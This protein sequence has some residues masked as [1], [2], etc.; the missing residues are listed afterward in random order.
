MIVLRSFNY[1]KPK[2][3]I[4]ISSILAWSETPQKEMIDEETG[5]ALEV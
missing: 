4:L 1:T 2:T 3:F 5:E